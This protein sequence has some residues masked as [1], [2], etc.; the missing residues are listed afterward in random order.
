MHFLEKTLFDLPAELFVIWWSYAIKKQIP[1][2]RDWNDIDVYTSDRKLSIII[3]ATGLE[4]DFQWWNEYQWPYMRESKE[5]NWKKIQFIL[6]F[7]NNWV[8]NKD[9]H[10]IIDWFFYE[11][12]GE[13]IQKKLLPIYSWWEKAEKNITDILFLAKNWKINIEIKIK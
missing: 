2:F 6:T 11:E 12:I 7:G 4:W 9:N 1:C 3:K 5:Y 8:T 10:T 13:T